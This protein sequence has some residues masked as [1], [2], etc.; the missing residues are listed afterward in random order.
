MSYVLLLKLFEVAKLAVENDR[1][2]SPISSSEY[3]IM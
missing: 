1:K 3:L 2:S